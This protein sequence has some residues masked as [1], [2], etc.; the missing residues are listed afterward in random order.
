MLSF[1]ILIGFFCSKQPGS[2][3]RTVIGK[4]EI[5]LEHNFFKSTV[6]P[7]IFLFGR[8]NN[9]DVLIEIIP[10]FRILHFPTRVK[11]ANFRTSPY[12]RLST[13]L[14]KGSREEMD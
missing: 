8:G 4:E 5:E 7:V 14:V 9:L 3:S 2:G 10:I 6:A 1:N 12:S 13:G 11:F